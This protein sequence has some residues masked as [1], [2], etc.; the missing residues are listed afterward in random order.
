MLAGSSTNGHIASAARPRHVVLTDDDP[1]ALTM[2]LKLVHLRHKGLP[3][4]L[5]PKQL[6]ALAVVTNK[7]ECADVISFAYINWSSLA[8]TSYTS[9]LNRGNLAAAAYMLGQPSEFRRLT[10]KL[11]F[12]HAMD[13]ADILP[14][15]EPVV[16]IKALSMCNHSVRATRW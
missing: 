10:K 2:L 12:S 13:S 3:S 16:P 14:L 9:F 11:V 4:A 8:E 6:L 1:L 5:T 7:Y 15:W